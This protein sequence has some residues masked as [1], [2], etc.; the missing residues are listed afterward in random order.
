[1]YGVYAPDAQTLRTVLDRPKRL[2]GYPFCAYLVCLARSVDAGA[3]AFLEKFGAAVDH[4][5][6]ESLAFIVLLD[7]ATVLGTYDPDGYLHKTRVTPDRQYRGWP[8]SGPFSPRA[9]SRDVPLLDLPET[10]EGELGLEQAVAKRIKAGSIPSNAYYRGSPEWSLKFA[11]HVGLNRNYLPCILAFDDP[12]ASEDENCIV[13]PLQDPAAAWESIRDAI[14]SF[15]I[16]PD[17]QVFIRAS[18]RLRKVDRELEIAA[19]RLSLVESELSKLKRAVSECG[20]VPDKRGIH[21]ALTRARTIIGSLP[22]APKGLLAWV[23]SLSDEDRSQGHG[24]VVK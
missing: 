12:L 2:L 19:N 3:L 11:D 9:N 20:V 8:S 15:V 16:Q 4:E 5:T 6:G 1:V 10:V 18:E 21:P 14:S 24:K 17:T 7:D 13:V 22:S 23:S